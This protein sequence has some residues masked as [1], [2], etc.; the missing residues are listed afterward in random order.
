MSLALDV[1]DWLSECASSPMVMDARFVLRLSSS[2]IIMQHRSKA[3]ERELERITNRVRDVKIYE[4][5]MAVWS[6]ILGFPM[7]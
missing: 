5:N 1:V 7:L 2:A 3:I 4:L 6:C